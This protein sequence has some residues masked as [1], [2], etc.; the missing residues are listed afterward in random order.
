MEMESHIQVMLIYS[1]RTS[2]AF[3]HL[4]ISLAGTELFKVV[5]IQVCSCSTPMPDSIGKRSICVQKYSLTYVLTLLTS[6]SIG[7][8]NSF[9]K[10]DTY[11]DF[12]EEQTN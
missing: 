12:P 3:C 7:S 8:V 10:Y 4:I 6:L 2:G 5:E 11:W 9:P 1:P